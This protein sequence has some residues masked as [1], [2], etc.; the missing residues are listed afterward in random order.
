[1]GYDYRAKSASSFG[2]IY[3]KLSE[4]LRNVGLK[5]I[6]AEVKTEK[7]LRKQMQPLL[8]HSHLFTNPCKSF[9]SFIQVVLFMGGA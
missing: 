1:M 8:Q 4:K 2:G 5:K 9:N 3:S 6:T 7:G